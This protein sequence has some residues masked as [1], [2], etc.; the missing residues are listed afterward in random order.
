MN[1]TIYLSLGS[2]KGKRLKNI[3]YAQNLLKTKLVCS[4]IISSPIYETKPMYYAKQQNFLNLVLKANTQLNPSKLLH[5]IKNIEK[6]IGRKSL[7]L[8]NHPREIDL[9]ILAYNNETVNMT[10][11]IIPH[12]KICERAFVLVPWNDISPNF[13]LVNMNKTISTLLNNLKI[14]DNSIKLYKDL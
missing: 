12:P 9:D 1:N 11:L 14:K 5:S 6:N 2:N 13:K 10:N 3:N 8:T 4:K 7:S